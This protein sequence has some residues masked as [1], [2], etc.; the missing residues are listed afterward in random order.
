MGRSYTDLV[1]AN[2]VIIARNVTH[3]LYA[4]HIAPVFLGKVV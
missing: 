1:Q 3:N 4:R 2:R